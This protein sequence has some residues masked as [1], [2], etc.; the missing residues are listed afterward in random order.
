MND[1]VNTYRRTLI[2]IGMATSLWANPEI[3]VELPNGASM[4][5][6]RIEAGTFSMGSPES[7]PGRYKDEGPQHQVTISRPFYLGKS[8]ITQRQWVAVMGTRP[9]ADHPNVQDGMD[10]PAAFITWDQ[11]QAFIDSLNDDGDPRFRLPTEAQWEYACRAGTATPWSSGSDE[12]QL[13]RH[14][15]F[16]GSSIHPNW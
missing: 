11:A 13:P 3:T 10:Y 9:W 16:G 1:G 12:S 4:V 14:A 15:W 8:E 6:V 5:F 7:E 2:L